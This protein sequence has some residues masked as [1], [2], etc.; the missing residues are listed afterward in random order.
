MTKLSGGGLTSNKL[1]RPGVKS[2]PAST[3]VVNPR[4]VSQ[5]GHATPGKMRQGAHTGDNTAEKVFERKAAEPP[6]GNAVSLNVGKGGPGTGRT[7]HYSGTQQQHGPS[8]G[9][10]EPF[11]RDIWRDYP[12]SRGAPTV[13]DRRR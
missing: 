2:G 8:A 3:N 5:Y 1:V 11:G 9:Q 12:G 13:G 7:V 6:M 4:G 10:R